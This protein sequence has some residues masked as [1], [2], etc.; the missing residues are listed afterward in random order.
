DSS[1]ESATDATA[2]GTARERSAPER[3]APE[4]SAPERS[5]SEPSAP[6][7]VA[8]ARASSAGRSACLSC[9]A[10]GFTPSLIGTR[11]ATHRVQGGPRRYDNF[12]PCL[13]HAQLDE[14]RDVAAASQHERWTS[15]WTTLSILAWVVCGSCVQVVESRR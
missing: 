12:V 1:V 6:I 15:L 7:L 10:A 13:H 2:S 8:S 4:R 14:T 3:S 5:A 9:P 11:C